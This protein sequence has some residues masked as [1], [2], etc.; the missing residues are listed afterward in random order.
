MAKKKLYGAALAAHNRKLGRS[1]STALARR[2][3]HAV[4]RRSTAVAKRGKPRTRTVTKTVYR[5]R[6]GAGAGGGRGVNGAIA[7]LKAQTW[8]LGAAATYGYLTGSDSLKAVEWRKKTLDH[9]PTSAKLGKPL[10]HGL[11]FLAAAAMLPNG[12][13]RRAAASLSHA[14]LMRAAHN[15]GASNFDTDAFATMSGDD[16]DEIAGEGAID[17]D[18]SE[19]D[20]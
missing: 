8:D 11:L 1:T 10:S 3:S 13:A 19:I 20:S 17:V 6:S 16:D 12:M 14:A 18:A 7:T 15:V 9:L 2:P 4:A 5:R